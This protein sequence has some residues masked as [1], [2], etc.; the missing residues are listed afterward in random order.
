MVRPGPVKLP[1]RKTTNGTVHY[2]WHWVWDYGNGDL[3]NQGIHE[4]D[5]ARW[6][7]NKNDAAERRSSASAAASATSTTARRPTRRSSASTTATAS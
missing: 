7:L 2:D 3:G 5:K 1:H 6:G 4:M